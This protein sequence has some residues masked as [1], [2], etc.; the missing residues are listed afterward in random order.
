MAVRLEVI[1]MRLS[2][3]DLEQVVIIRLCKLMM[4]TMLDLTGFEWAEARFLELEMWAMEIRLNLSDFELVVSQAMPVPSQKQVNSQISPKKPPLNLSYS[5]VVK[6]NPN[7]QTRD[8]GKCQVIKSP[9][10]SCDPF[11]PQA[12][13]D[14]LTCDPG[15]SLGD[16]SPTQ[17][18]G[19][20]NFRNRMHLLI[21]T[22]K[23]MG[24]INKD[25]MINQVT[26]LTMAQSTAVILSHFDHPYTINL[27]ALKG[28]LSVTHIRACPKAVHRPPCISI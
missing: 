5:Q 10:Q 18:P 22:W 23:T 4:A 6:A 25:N 8:P 12:S 26:R 9:D 19:H 15:K 13:C 14:Q 28:S 27:L 11:V 7:L 17:S 20:V 3:A 21:N 2:L 24:I 16:W 1:V